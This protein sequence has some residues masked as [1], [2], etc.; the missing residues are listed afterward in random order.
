MVHFMEFR[1]DIRVLMHHT[2]DIHSESRQ[3]SAWNSE[4]EDSEIAHLLEL[5]QLRKHLHR[6]RLTA[7]ISDKN[8]T[9]VSTLH[10]EA[11][12]RYSTLSFRTRTVEPSISL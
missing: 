7:Y 3:A 10:C 5:G 6:L 11:C 8:P 9:D 2:M 12:C 4:K 1:E